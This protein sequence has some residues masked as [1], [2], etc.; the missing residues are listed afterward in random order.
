MKGSIFYIIIRPL[1]YLY[2]IIFYKV[3]AENNKNIPKKGRVIL[4]GNHTH[5][6]DC[7]T[8]GYSTTRTVRFIAKNELI[9]GKKGLFFKSVG[10]IPVDR[11][12][13]D[14]TVI[15][16]AVKY[17]KKGALI[18][19]FP[20]GTI[21]RTNDIIM[22]FKKGAIKM[23]LASNSPIIPFAISGKYNKEEGITITFGELYYPKSDDVIKETKIL[24]EKVKKI[25]LNKKEV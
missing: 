3:K 18:A 16:C 6:L 2:F 14:E 15:P 13:K 22:P 25:L 12:K 11:T 4:V 8:L 17:L 24:E 23:A 10:I 1:V 7:L 20:E 5:D 9:R 19:I 21:N